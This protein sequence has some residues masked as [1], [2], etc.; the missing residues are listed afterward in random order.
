MSRAFDK[1]P[2]LTLY[3][4]LLASG[5]EPQLAAYI[6]DLHSRVRFQVKI[7]DHECQ[8]A[9]GQGLRQGCTLAPTLW[10]VYA[11][12]LLRAISC[13][14]G[15]DWVATCATAFS[16]DLLF[17]D[18]FTSLA[19]LRLALDRM[20]R[21][22]RVL[23]DMGMTPNFAKS[24]FM[25]ASHG[26]QAQQHLARPM[27]TPLAPK[28]FAPV[29]LHGANRPALEDVVPSAR[30]SP[31]AVGLLTESTAGRQGMPKGA[32]SCLG[33][34]FLCTST[35]KAAM[36][37]LQEDS[38]TQQVGFFQHLLP[39]ANPTLLSQMGVKGAEP[40]E[41]APSKHRRLDKGGKGHGNGRQ[42]RG[43]KRQGQQGHQAPQQG[44]AP[45]GPQ[46]DMR[47]ILPLVLRMLLRQEDELQMI[48]L[49]KAF[50]LFVDP[51]QGD[52]C[53][54][55]ALYKIAKAWKDKRD[56]DPPQVN[57]PLRMIMLEALLTEMKNRLKLLSENAEAQEMA[58]KNQWAVRQGESLYWQFQSWDPATAK[59]IIHPKREPILTRT[60]EERIEE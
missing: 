50:C 28:T 14:C 47:Y 59:V 20:V 53:I 39:S 34:N 18:T 23:Q 16:D 1:V 35:N 54:L 38:V 57:A 56:Q 40:L 24:A 29:F 37:D 58:I 13:A 15:P 46:L 33:L 60:V 42:T 8:V 3:T 52:G 9:G 26:W 17:R 51:V 12:A 43:Q 25:V 22:F 32:L 31:E 2:W 36:A 4:S 10:L 27:S 48:R 55:K 45:R 44:L 6:I 7:G 41:G 30:A 11:K 21:I 5:V 19:G 49:D